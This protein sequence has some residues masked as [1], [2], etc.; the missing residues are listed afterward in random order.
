MVVLKP[1]ARARQDG[2]RVYAVILGTAVNQDGRTSGL[3]VP[4]Q[5][6]QEA[7]CSR[8]LPAGGYRAEPSAVR[9]SAWNRHA[10]RRSHRGASAGKCSWRESTAGQF[11]PSRVGQDEPRSSGARRRDCGVDQ[12]RP[13]VAEPDGAAQPLLRRTESGYPVR[14]A[15]APRSAAPANRWPE[16]DGPALAGVNSFG[17]GGANAHVIVKGVAADSGERAGTPG[18]SR[19]GA[20]LSCPCRREVRKRFAP[21]PRRITA[22]S[23]AGWSRCRG[24]TRGHFLDGVPRRSHHDHRVAL[25]AGSARRLVELLGAHAAN[26]HRSSHRLG[27]ADV[28]SPSRLAFMCAGQGPQWWAMGRSSC[29][30]RTLSSGRSSRLAIDLIETHASWSLLE[31][32]TADEPRSRLHETAHRAAGHLRPAGCPRQALAKPGASTPD[33][34][35]GHSVG[36]VRGRLPRRCLHLEEAVRIISSAAAPWIGPPAGPNARGGRD[37]DEADRLVHRSATRSRSPR[38]MAD[39]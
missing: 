36:E 33:A 11:L 1:L 26:E 31:V 23:P 20:P 9:R 22:L 13:G 39:S 34:V 18:A 7:G 15:R 4:S 5:E 16:P 25:V 8:G 32:L 6:A 2:D 30:K 10:G 37:R 12:G 3:T 38:S 27:P 28:I 35:V 21:W 17:F 14:A 24:S 29:W 19:L